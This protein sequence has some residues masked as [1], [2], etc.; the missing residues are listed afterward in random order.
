[1]F[2]ELVYDKR[3]VE[4]LPGAREIILN[5]LTKR[6]HQ[7]FPA[8][9]VKVK[10]MQTNALNSDCTKTEKE[11]LSRMLEEMFEEADMWLVAE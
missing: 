2:V 3:N 8:A 5:E 1:M 4:G 6:V 10:P 11:R 7:I 9:Q